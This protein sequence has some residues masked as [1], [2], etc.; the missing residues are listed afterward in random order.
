MRCL[1]AAELWPLWMVGHGIRLG[2]PHMASM[3]EAFAHTTQDHN[4]LLEDWSGAFGVPPFA[5]IEPGYFLPA[6]ARA[7]AAHSREVAAIAAHQ[8]APT[9]AN[10]IDAL[11]TA[12]AAL[13]RVVQRLRSAG[14]CR[15]PTTRFSRSSASSRRS[16][17]STGTG[18]SWTRPCSAASI[19]SIARRER[20]GLTPEQA[21]VLER[22][23]CDVQARGRG[24]RRRRRRRG[25]PLSTSGSP[26]SAP[27]FSQNVL[28]DEQG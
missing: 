10:T 1:E 28:A 19:G 4:P 6:F 14:R 13:T 24:A 11:E 8:A 9:F 21:R 25:L 5:R 17:P 12:G 23:H 2:K 27:T 15:T 3:N 22:Y 18:F 26:R 20:L 16:R 7:F